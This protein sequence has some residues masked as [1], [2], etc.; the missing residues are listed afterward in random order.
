MA[1]GGHDHLCGGLAAG[2]AAPGQALVSFGT[3]ASLL[4]PS[5]KFH[6]GGAVFA[7]GLSCY[8][9]VTEERYI[10][11]GGLSAAGAA[12]AWLARLLRGDTRPEDYAALEQAALESPPGARGLV[13]LP[14]L[15]GSGTP[16]REA[17]SVWG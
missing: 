13:C 5:A 3:A 15:R 7:Q 12:L 9:Y 14:H 17:A 8:C 6:G 2:V 11:Q 1:T 4:A 16:E 10:V